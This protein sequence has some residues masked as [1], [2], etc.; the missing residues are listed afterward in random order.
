MDNNKIEKMVE[1][2]ANW[3]DFVNMR[4]MQNLTGCSVSWITAQ[5]KLRL[6]PGAYKE[7]VGNCDQWFIPY[8]YV[9]LYRKSENMPKKGRPKKDGK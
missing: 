3:P 9:I 1:T 5:I 6:M 7:R 4:E 8:L 2:P